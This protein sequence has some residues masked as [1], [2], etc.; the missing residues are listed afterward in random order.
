[1]LVTH[2]GKRIAIASALRWA[3]LLVAIAACKTGGRAPDA[4]RNAAAPDVA[5]V[6]M[7]VGIRRGMTICPGNGSAQPREALATTTWARYT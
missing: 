2:G 5:Q 3:L 7:A 6:S 1:L 4:R